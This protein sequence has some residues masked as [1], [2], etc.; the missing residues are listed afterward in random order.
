MPINL[1]IEYPKL[2]AE[3]TT[4]L[5]ANSKAAEAYETIERQLSDSEAENTR[6]REALRNL[7][8]KAQNEEVTLSMPETEEIESLLNIDTDA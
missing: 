3:N 4:L 8:Q 5:A 2:V 6:L 1:Q 7:Y